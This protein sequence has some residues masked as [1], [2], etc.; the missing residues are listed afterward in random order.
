M[1]KLRDW[2][3]NKIISKYA[4]EDELQEYSIEEYKSDKSNA[5]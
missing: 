4:N 5:A 1:E 2:S 3:F